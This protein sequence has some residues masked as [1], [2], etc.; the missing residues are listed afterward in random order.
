MMGRSFLSAMVF[1]LALSVGAAP[2]MAQGKGVRCMSSQYSEAQREQLN[3]LGP[4]M[5]LG[6]EIDQSVFDQIGDIAMTAVAS[7]VERNGWNEELVLYASFYEL[8]RLNEAA[9]RASGELTAD[10]I[11]RLDNALATGDRERLWAV[12]EQG[13]MGG[14]MGEEAG[15]VSNSEAM[16]MGA[17]LLG[18]GLLEGPG[19]EDV[20]EK[21]GLLLGFMGLQRIG[22]RQ[23]DALN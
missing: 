1:G 15:D 8:G 18:A 6:S 12:V 16:V 9:Y 3:E 23:F 20:A 10:Q 7:C 2:A 19:D 17:F 22:R 14:V 4:R 21:V 5:A 11:T 13:V